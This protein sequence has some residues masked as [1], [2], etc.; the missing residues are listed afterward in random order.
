MARNLRALPKLR[1]SLSFAYV[2]HARIEQSAKAVTIVD[3]SG[4]TH[5][6]VAAMA[7]L[8]LG[9][10]TTITHAAMKNL[11]D[12]GCSVVWVGED[13]TR[14]YGSGLGE[15][16]SAKRLMRQ[17]ACFVD[18]E[19]RAAVVRRMYEKRFREPLPPDL[20]LNQVRGREGVR[21]R[22]A[23]AQLSRTY[24]VPWSGRRYERGRWGQTD[25]ANRALSA[26][27]A[28]L[29]GVCHSAIVAVGYCPGLGFIHTGKLLSFVY[30]VADLYRVD[31]IMPPA[32]RVAAEYGDGRSHKTLD[33]DVRRACRDA[34][35]EAKLLKRLVG[36]LDQL[37]EFGAEELEL[38]SAMLDGLSEEPAA[39]WAGDRVIEGGRNYGG[40]DP[41]DGTDE[42]T[43]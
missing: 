13:G 11:G 34:F 40:P 22:E 38:A 41:G 3:P 15:T 4:E 19:H 17:V 28:C 16:R 18:V 33:R 10:G 42:P 12:A 25:A 21:V 24:G 43:G 6:P 36:D 31:V 26:A 1:D 27:A 5:I 30:D 23:Y 37:F 14:V 7:V 39:L 32:F 35:R 20:T 2:E 29:Y 8:L 9:P